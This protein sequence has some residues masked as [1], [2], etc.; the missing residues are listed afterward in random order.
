[1]VRVVTALSGLVLIVLALRLAM[2]PLFPLDKF[3]APA[4]TTFE[5]ETGTL[6]KFRNA[7]LTLL[8]T[9]CVVAADVAIELPDGLGSVHADR[10]LLAL[11]PLPVLSGSAELGSVTIERPI[12]NL[13]LKGRD[14]DPSRMIAAL[15]NLAS[16]AT[17]RHFLATD[18]RLVIS[19]GGTEASFE[20]LTASAARAEEGHRLVLKATLQDKPLSLTIEAGSA[21]AA[22]AQFTTAALNIDLDGGLAG[23]AFAGRLELSAPDAAAFGGPFAAARGPMK[24]S[25]AVSLSSDRIELVDAAAIAFGG[26]GRL[27]AALDLSAPRASVDL[28]A[29]FSR[30]PAG[31]LAALGS[32]ATHLGFDPAGG[33]APFD[34]GLDLKLAELTLP[35]GGMRNLRFTAVDRDGRFGALFDGAAGD[36][37][38]SGRL[39]LVP[40]GDGRRLGASFSAKNVDVGNLSMIAGL[41]S[42]PLSGRLAADLRMAAHGRTAD[43][44]A[45]TLSIDGAGQVRGGHLDALPLSG[46]IKL[47]ALTDLSADLSVVGIDKPA[48]LTAQGTA[49]SGA[50]TFEMT[51]PARQLLGGGA[52]PVEVRVEGPALSAGF[53]GE[54]DPAAASLNGSLTMTSSRL[55]VLTGIADLPQSASLDG[56]LE[57]AAGRFTLSDVRLMLGDVAFGGVL[58]LAT[59][60][61][62]E[63]L[64]GRLSGDMVDVG[65][66]AGALANG[67]SKAGQQPAIIDADLHVEAGRIVAGPVAAAGGPVDFR[68]GK[69]GG[70]ISLPKLSLGGGSGFATLTVKPGSQPGYTIRGKLEG[71]RLASLAPLIGN[72]V[73]GELALAVDIGAAG[74]KRSDLFKSAAGTADFSIAHG[75]LD[76][77]DPVALLG[78]LARSVQVGFGTDS[79]R[80]GF[81]KLNG[82]LKLSNGTMTADELVLSAGDLQLSGTGTLGLVGGNL[83]M[84][85]R[86]TLKGY[87][88]FEVPVAVVGSLASPRLYPD[89]PGLL[90]DSVSGYS[91]LATMTG[92]FARLIGGDATP[93]LEPVKP[94][95]VTSM[96]DT[97]SEA[98][99][100]AEAPTAVPVAVVAAPS[101][102]AEPPLP[103]PLARPNGLVSA[104][105]REQAAARSPNVAEGGPLDLG[106]LGRVAGGVGPTPSPRG[107]QCRPGRDG[108]C[109]P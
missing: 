35:G 74:R 49:P 15:A 85:L 12:L 13:A 31:S 28:H 53:I 44:L 95:A 63:H 5:T 86:P 71:A 108:R 18:G 59:V 17:S 60:D 9:P 27:S 101:A 82:R 57:A 48:R 94:D 47:P 83:D 7:D 64:T 20:G 55:P 84:R 41:P 33:P 2:A 90:D 34:A 24:L 29:D 87:P 50:V 104:P 43:E 11:S 80:V 96:I 4:I 23:G 106:A 58:D 14:L 51:A 19:T 78:R 97:L 76:G 54:A 36:G 93:K 107:Y 46:A 42:S 99:K 73:D 70:E 22:R 79:G 62:Q 69:E 109:I 67:P 77:L 52:A 3:V 61:S 45:A 26:N 8:P 6:V 39:D 103:L 81:D 91:R 16:L 38:L 30:L 66:L 1:M 98:P 92:G 102:I 75:L 25:G 56:Q 10:L 88:E 40:D 32:L 68:V 65:A 100:P 105:R 37:V 21:G 72:M 89:L